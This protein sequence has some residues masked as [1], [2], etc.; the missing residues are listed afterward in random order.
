M[1]AHKSY[2]WSVTAF[3]KLCWIFLWNQ[4]RFFTSF[5]MNHCHT[6]HSKISKREN[7]SS[8]RLLILFSNEITS[9]LSYSIARARDIL[10]KTLREWIWGVMPKTFQFKIVYIDM[11]SLH[12]YHPSMLVRLHSSRDVGISHVCSWSLYIAGFS[13]M[14]SWHYISNYKYKIFKKFR[15]IIYP[16]LKNKTESNTCSSFKMS[17]IA[18]A[19][20]Q[21]PAVWTDKMK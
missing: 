12:R 4:P 1:S 8:W 14:E 17:G 15:R 5:D 16:I 11:D 18:G 3:G 6:L 10:T 9:Q 21:K 2:G 7:T 19:C 13:S 20:T